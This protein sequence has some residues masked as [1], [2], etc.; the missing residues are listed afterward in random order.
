MNPQKEKVPL[1][2]RPEFWFLNGKKAFSFVLWC[3]VFVV[4][5]ATIKVH[6][7]GIV[8]AIGIVL[9]YLY[10]LLHS[11]DPLMW[12]ALIALVVLMDIRNKLGE[13][14][15]IEREKKAVV[16]RTWK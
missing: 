15:K 12:I 11:V 1:R 3:F 16:E 10:D 2:D 4:V 13:I 5:M 14:L 9:S 8:A 6:G 7:D